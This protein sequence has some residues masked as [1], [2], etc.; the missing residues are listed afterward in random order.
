MWKE[1]Q[2]AGWSVEEIESERQQKNKLIVEK[3]K[4][5]L[6]EISFILVLL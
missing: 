4:P 5:E 1:E 2:K 3:G 6:L